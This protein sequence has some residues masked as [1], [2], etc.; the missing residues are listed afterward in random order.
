[1]LTSAGDETV[2]W[3]GAVGMLTFQLRRC[4]ELRTLM[5]PFRERGILFS[6]APGVFAVVAEV[7]GSGNV[8]RK[9]ELGSQCKV[10][11]VV[12]FWEEGL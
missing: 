2:S 12:F 8:S 1:M 7:T 10:W 3:D 9:K 5:P 11:N 4:K 6:G